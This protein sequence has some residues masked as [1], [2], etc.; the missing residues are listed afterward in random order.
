MDD[1]DIAPSKIG[2]SAQRVVDRALEETR[3]RGHECV[4]NEHV[5]LAFTHLQWDMF[6]EV[7]RD[8]ELNPH[9]IVQALDA[10]RR[11][12]IA[13]EIPHPRR[14]GRSLLLA[15]EHEH[16]VAFRRQRTHERGADETRTAGHENLHGSRP[17]SLVVRRSF[18]FSFPI[19]PQETSAARTLP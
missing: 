16:L 13:G 4:T 15:H 6:S 14:G 18:P 7:M 12:G 3:R 1:F 2:E 17:L 11:K 19:I 5:L 10:P 8:L 9:E